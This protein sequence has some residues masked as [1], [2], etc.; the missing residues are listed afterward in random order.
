VGG[1]GVVGE[2]VEF[3]GIVLGVEGGRVDGGGGGLGVV[4]D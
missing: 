1:D 2:F 3:G 4:D